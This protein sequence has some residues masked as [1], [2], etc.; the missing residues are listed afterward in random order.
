MN[1]KKRLILWLLL[2]LLLA[3]T[4]SGCRWAGRLIFT[5]FQAL[6][7]EEART[8]E[9]PAWIST[10][11]P[12]PDDVDVPTVTP[13]LETDAPD[14]PADTTTETAS[15]EPTEESD[16]VHTVTTN[17]K[18]AAYC[19]TQLTQSQRNAYDTIYAAISD[20]NRI[21]M[22]RTGESY[23]EVAVQYQSVSNLSDEVLLILEAIIMDHPEL[24]YLLNTYSYAHNSAVTKMTEFTIYTMPKVEALALQD[25]IQNGIA[26]YTR[27]VRGDLD[28]YEIAKQ[29][30][31]LLASDLQYSDTGSDRAHNIVGAFVDGQCVC[32]GYAKAYQLLLN[33][34][35]IS[36]FTV[37]GLGY[38]N[39]GI[40]ENHR[41]I[42]VQVNGN[43]YYSDPTWADLKELDG[44]AA[45]K[46]GYTKVSY[47]YFNMTAAEMGVDHVLDANSQT[48]TANLS[49]TATADNYFVKEGGYFARFNMSTAANY[50][51]TQIGNAL[52][53]NNEIVGIK[54]A[55]EVDYRTMITYI[56]SNFT[57]LY[58]SVPET[59]GQSHTLQYYT[60]DEHLTIHLWIH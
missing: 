47:T 1:N 55:N 25:A 33:A 38:G 29:L 35:G 49:F 18:V 15:S 52:R 6:Y 31:E 26:T 48:V 2:V 45:P 9:A 58:R 50:I 37:S 3:G 36:A 30:F 54:M 5:P 8:S 14:L 12:I 40:P 7:G 22:D 41:W 44:S 23:I 16:A 17:S 10:P 53:T 57:S 11:T 59:A 42:A 43:W 60:E 21:R 20:L 32:E 24:Y 13:A 56:R 4:L 34:Y 51:R 27:Q 28:Q 46:A 39:D 19:R